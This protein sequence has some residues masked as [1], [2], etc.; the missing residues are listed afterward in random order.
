MVEY[1]IIYIN[2]CSIWFNFI[3]NIKLI[4]YNKSKS[5]NLNTIILWSHLFL[6]SEAFLLR[7]SYSVE[8][9]FSNH[10]GVELTLY[11][12]A[13]IVIYVYKLYI[14]LYSENNSSM[15]VIRMWSLDNLKKM[16]NYLMKK[17][18]GDKCSQ[19]QGINRTSSICEVWSQ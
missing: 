16:T 8:Y 14:S 2:I 18:A 9:K 15:L 7:C 17:K 12:P 3:Y 5:L 19:S 6:F 10:L 1:R 13:Y 11:I 4:I